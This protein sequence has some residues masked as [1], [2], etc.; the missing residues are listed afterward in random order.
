MSEH[1]GKF[2]GV[3]GTYYQVHR[4][5]DGRLSN[6][7]FK[8]WRGEDAERICVEIRFDDSCKNGHETFSITA[9]GKGFGGCCHGLII[10]HFPEFEPLIQW[11]LCSI[12]GP[13][14]YIASATYHAGDM[15]HNGRRKGEPDSC[16][17]RIYFG[18]FPIGQN[19]SASFAQWLHAVKDF[20]IVEVVSFGH[21]S[22]GHVYRDK[23]TLKYKDK[24]Y[25]DSVWASCP[26]NTEQEAAEFLAALKYTWHIKQVPISWSKGKERDLDAARRIAIWPDAK[27]EILSLPRGDL[28][29]I[30]EGRLP[31]LLDAFQAAIEQT[32]FIYPEE[33]S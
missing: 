9:H 11:H 22:D 10:E 15:D 4:F 23:F 18:T 17:H 24:I 21:V 16:Q 28:T 26:F 2:Y 1:R 6:Q 32:E 12:D 27:D 14:H 3:E 31:G 29:R 8:A 30:L 5:E 33:R 20:G 19:L 7:T 13:M 25:G